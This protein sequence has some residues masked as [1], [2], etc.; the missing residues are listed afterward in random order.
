MAVLYPNETSDEYILT[1]LIAKS[2]NRHPFALG[3]SVV[4]H[5]SYSTH[6]QLQLFSKTNILDKYKKLSIDYFKSNQ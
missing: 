2:Y 5:F 6:G 1:V 3:S 4:S